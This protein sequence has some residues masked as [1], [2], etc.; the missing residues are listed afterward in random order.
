MKDHATSGIGIGIAGR[1]GIGNP[2]QMIGTS[3]L[4]GNTQS[5]A[6]Q[7]HAV[8]SHEQHVHA[9]YGLRQYWLPFA[10]GP[11]QQALKMQKSAFVLRSLPS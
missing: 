3:S 8:D 2:A 4:H 5:C 9:V 6:Q 7:Q 10:I 1:I 11:R